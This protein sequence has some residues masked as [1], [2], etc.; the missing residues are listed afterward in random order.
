MFNSRDEADKNAGSTRYATTRSSRFYPGASVEPSRRQLIDRLGL[1]ID[2]V[3][4]DDIV[5]SMAGAYTGIFYALIDLITQ[6]WGAEAA[7]EVA[8]ALGRTNGE[9]NLRQWLDSRN[10]SQGS[11]ELMAA[12][13]DYQH[14]MR[15][16]DHAAAVSRYDDDEAV[17]DRPR[18]AWH[19]RRPEGTE[20]FCK[21][22]SQGIIAGYGAADPALEEVRIAQCMSW[23]DNVCQHQFR[24]VRSQD[25]AEPSEARA[26]WRRN[27]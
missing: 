8:S 7:R 22:V 1:D 14:A 12:F 19:T 2:N 3:T 26:V 18:C 9:R 5:T 10:E 21:Y 23:D 4:V 20:S 27:S 6:R 16:P 24:Y 25:D 15:G 17:V 11:P 13:Q